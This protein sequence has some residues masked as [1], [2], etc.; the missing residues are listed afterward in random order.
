MQDDKWLRSLEI[1]YH[2]VREYVLHWES[3]R[4]VKYTQRDWSG[5]SANNPKAAAKATFKEADAP[6]EI[7]SYSYA[8]DGEL[9]QVTEAIDLQDGDPPRPEVKY[10]RI[11][12]GVTLNLLLQQAEDLLVA[13]I[14]KT[15]QAAK[16]RKR[17]LA[18]FFS[19]RE[20]IPIRM[21]SLHRCFSL[22]IA[23]VSDGC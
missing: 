9:E 13:E 3:D 14:P 18:C 23:C 20:S 21:V 12:K 22:P 6:Q 19:L 2:G 15:I 7:Y 11:P 16:V 17:F 1:G 4:L 8:A 10:Q 5:V